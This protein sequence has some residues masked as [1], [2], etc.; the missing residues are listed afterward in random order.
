MFSRTV[1]FMNPVVTAIS[2]LLYLTIFC[3][4]QC[5]QICSLPW[6]HLG[7]LFSCNKYVSNVHSG[8]RKKPD[9]ILYAA[10]SCPEKFLVI[11][12]MKYK[13]HLYD[14]LC[15]FLSFQKNQQ[16]TAEFDNSTAIKIFTPLKF[17]FKHHVLLIR[18]PGTTLSSSFH[19]M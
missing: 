2:I 10:H 8:I 6:K 1:Y 13:I 9:N 4:P 11:F 14:Y 5:Y 15:T 19:T 7:V 3:C 17:G 18:Y 12:C 16:V